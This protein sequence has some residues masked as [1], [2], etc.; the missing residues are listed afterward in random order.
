MA[1]PGRREDWVG[2]GGQG[3]ADAGVPVS[4]ATAAGWGLAGAGPECFVIEK[5]CRDG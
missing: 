3:S 2:A 4:L 1:E 5:V